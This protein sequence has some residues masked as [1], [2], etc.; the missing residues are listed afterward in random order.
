MSNWVLLRG[1][2][3]EKRHWGDFVGL[4]QLQFPHDR[5][6]TIDGLGNGEWHQRRSPHRIIDMVT[7][8]QTELKQCQANA[9]YHLVALSLGA[10]VA[11]E[12]AKLAPQQ[13]ASATLI[14]TSL[15]PY[16]PFYQRLRPRNYPALFQ[17]M[18]STPEEQER[19]IL[20]FTSNQPAKATLMRWI[21]YQQQYPISRANILRQLWAAATY[22]APPVAPPIRLQFL[23][24]EQDQLVNNQCSHTLARAWHQPHAVHPSAGHD[25]TLDA[26]EWVIQQLFNFINQ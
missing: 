17:L 1:L 2:M 4:L 13:I 26:P 15:R 3:R 19:L 11:I 6:L 20:K 7:H 12:W 18:N 24:S 25:L 10:M 14:N 22:R 23:S 8:L 9:P 16:N 5:I 21:E